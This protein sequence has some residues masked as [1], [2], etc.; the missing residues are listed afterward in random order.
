[1][2]ERQTK[3]NL[4]KV[5]LQELK[6]FGLE[7]EQIFVVAHDNGANMCASVPFLM[8]LSKPASEEEIPLS[9]IL[10][11]EFKTMAEYKSDELGEIDRHDETIDEHEIEIEPTTVE[12][13]E[14]DDFENGQN[15]TADI[16]VNDDNTE[17]LE[18]LNSI[19]CGAHTL[20]LVAYD[21]LKLYKTR[22]AQI[23][24]ICLAM[25]HKTNRELFVLHKIP[26]PPKVNE[27]RWGVWFI[28]QRYLQVLRTK[29]FLATLQS[30]DPS[31]GKYF[32]LFCLHE[33]ILG[34]I[35]IL[36]VLP[37]LSR[38]WHFIDR[39]CQ[40]FEPIY[41]LTLKLQKDH[42]PLS[43]FYANWL[44]CQAELHLIK[45]KGNT[46]AAKLLTSMERR[47][48]KLITSMAFKACLYLDPRF[49]F[50]GSGRLSPRDKK[51]AQVKTF[52][53]K[54]LQRYTNVDLNI[55]WFPGISH[56]VE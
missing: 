34:Y 6:T 30:Q 48:N 33:I 54:S 47:I 36:C 56:S 38:H 15:G 40:A 50:A 23:N 2:H 1:M 32:I 46:L 49:N 18:I 28:L 8:S 9:Q 19:R 24:K 52:F 12:K 17:E 3:E 31:L 10:P 7:I 25:H 39:F 20:Q 35:L 45:E 43:E 51:D 21:V 22:L 13:E 37:D 11:A 29:P 16:V 5:V 42:V 53:L 14:L 27:T 44:I 26:L 41:I 4:A 55:M